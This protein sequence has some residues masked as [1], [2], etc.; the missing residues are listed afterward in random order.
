MTTDGVLFSWQ[1]ATT[2]P[3]D[4][5]VRPSVGPVRPIQ[6]LPHGH[7]RLWD[8]NKGCYVIVCVDNQ[9][10]IDWWEK[11]WEEYIDTYGSHT[12]TP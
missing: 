3:P 11:A 2:P 9:D 4:R 10:Y 12:C 1:D 8:E 5:S 6:D 7:H